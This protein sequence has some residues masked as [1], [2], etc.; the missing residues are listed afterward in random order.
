[1]SENELAKVLA[2]FG[3]RVK[4][5]RL[6]GGENELKVG[7]DDYL[8]G[9]SPE[10]LRKLIDDVKPGERK[11]TVRILDP[12]RPFP[13]EALP[14]P[15]R[16]FTQEAAQS[17]GCDPAFVALPALAVVASAIGNTRTI[18]LK[19][20][21]QEP[22]ILWTAVIAESGTLK[23]PAHAKVL[24]P[25]FALQ[26]TLL[27]EHHL[28]IAQH[29][30]EI[31]AW[32]ER[33]A[34]CKK[35]GGIYQE[36]PPIEPV[37]RRVVVSDT[38]VQ[39]L[40]EILEDNPRGTLVARDELSGWLASFTRFSPR[41]SASDV[42]NWLEMHRAGT[43]IIDRKTGDRTTLFVPHA[44]VSV[45]G[46]IQPGIFAKA[47]RPGDLLEAGLVARL[48]PAMPNKMPKVWTDAEMS[49]ETEESF[50]DLL[51]K[52]LDLDFDLDAGEKVP[53]MLRL[54]PD[55]K[56]LWVQFYDRWGQEQAAAEGD[57]AAALAKLEAYAA[58]LALMHHVVHMAAFEDT[59]CRP[60]TAVSLQA[61]IV[62][63]EWF[64]NEARRIYCTFTET[65]TERNTRRLIEFIRG[66]GGS[67]TVRDLQRS[68]SRKYPTSDHAE[69]AL[70]Q[71]VPDYG[72]WDRS[73]PPA[74]GGHTTHTF[75][76]HPTHD[77]S[78]TRFVKEP[79]VADTRTDTCSPT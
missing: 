47:L 51:K 22:S 32:K 15:V 26:K 24:K 66:Q 37:K 52:L 68:N 25:L 20:G 77:T 38:T 17:L 3:A 55:A 13:V 56:V 40:G 8:L 4:I 76:L 41:Q 27:D 72:F 11:Q 53:L 59:S 42:P 6:P 9:H 5:V 21:W 30:K 45:A 50:R 12:Y 14:G 31:E 73:P 39:K 43:I 61:G 46:T 18:Q 2:A 49:D 60:V 79:G 48:L 44:A 1:L 75:V 29:E 69:V 71:L 16:A 78:D 58:R 57:L 62:L 36:P 54:T 19:R 70:S 74:T 7:L 10:D 65:E 23:S 67:I 63:C 33:K 64:A 35:A 28:K 34:K